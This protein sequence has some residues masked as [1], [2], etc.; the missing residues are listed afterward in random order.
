MAVAD[1]PPPPYVVDASALADGA[2]HFDYFEYQG[3]DPFADQVAPR[4]Y[5]NPVLA[6]F[7][8]DPSITRVGEDFYLVNST[9]A[10]W[11]GVPIF[12]SRDLVNWRQL[13]HVLDR[14]SQL[15]LDGLGVS[16]GIFAPAIE[17]HEGVFYLITTLVDGGGNFVVTARDPAGPWS[18]PVWLE[19]EGIDPSL[20]F[21]DDGRAWVVNNGAPE[22]ALL[23]EG[24]RAIWLQEFDRAQQRLVG[25][26]RVLVNGGV[27]LAEQPV[28]IE[29]PH[30]FKR[31]GYYYL[32][33]AEGGTAEAHRQV[34]FRSRRVTGP[35][36]PWAENP[37]LTQRDLPAD[38]PHPVTSTGH[39]DLVETPAGEWWAVFLGCRPYADDHYN[40][41]RETFLL[42]VTWTADGW[43]RILPRGE[44]VPHTVRR[45]AL[46]PRWPP[47]GPVPLTGSFTV[48]E[49]FTAGRLPPE[50]LMLRTPRERWL[51]FTARP[52]ALTLRPRSETLASAGQPAFVARRQQH[53]RFTALTSVGLTGEAAGTAAGLVA[54]QNEQHYFALLLERTTAGAAL[55]LE[56]A[57]GGAA[58]A[59]ARVP[60]TSE[61]TWPVELRITAD[62]A[63]YRFAY[64]LAPGEWQDVGGVL[65]G[66]T[67]STRT[68][69][70]F[71]GA[72][73]GLHAVRR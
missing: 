4:E 49:E 11:P 71:V 25:P 31:D 33:C 59:R 51:S 61:P 7:Y 8:P 5:L 20:F 30:L 13:G 39:A 56:V 10:Y 9:F 69:G 40:T 62:G 21:D 68:A 67:L 47:G 53:A 26:R 63:E 22:G 23:Y 50:W 70:G 28:W 16:R 1:L 41:G 6:G 48:R 54:F 32:T 19:F 34:V 52:G 27:N 12:H 64:A 38:R 24:H 37:I 35:F 60:L 57:A 46:P 45:P 55:V 18:D 73:V 2:A 65:D 14:P 3:S 36:E 29:G 15:N 72:T 66:R 44:P 42:P 17:H 43:P 58:A